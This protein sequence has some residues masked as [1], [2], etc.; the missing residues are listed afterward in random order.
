MCAYPGHSDL[1]M[2]KHCW[3]PR[4]LQ[5]PMEYFLFA[6]YHGVCGKCSLHDDREPSFAPPMTLPVLLQ[7]RPAVRPGLVSNYILYIHTMVFFGFLLSRQCVSQSRP[8]VIVGYVLELI[9][10]IL[11]S[12]FQNPEVMLLQTYF[13]NLLQSSGADEIVLVRDN[14]PG[15]RQCLHP[16]DTTMK[17]EKR[18]KRFHPV[19]S[20]QSP[21][22][23]PLRKESNDQL[24]SLGA[25]KRS[26]S[27]S[28]MNSSLI[29]FFAEV[30][31]PGELLK[32]ALPPKDCSSRQYSSRHLRPQSKNVSSHEDLCAE[33]DENFIAILDEVLRIEEII[34]TGCAASTQEQPSPLRMSPRS[35]RWGAQSQHS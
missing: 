30:A 26:S 32:I 13:S 15:P 3:K 23:C 25:S 7:Y 34:S 9:I 21:P 10:I 19:S 12:P 18:K 29:S 11:N 17:M 27:S 4:L 33:K 5:S 16:G 6:N 20:D 22:S 2:G 8:S 35:A 14:A 24:V 31:L 1:E 28:R